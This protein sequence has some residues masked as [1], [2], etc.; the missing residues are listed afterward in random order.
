MLLVLYGTEGNYPELSLC[1]WISEGS[2]VLKVPLVSLG[3]L[4]VRT[5]FLGNTRSE[6]FT[7]KG[8]FAW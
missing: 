6:W 7:L 5:V 1:G 8:L 2:P 3:D 4:T